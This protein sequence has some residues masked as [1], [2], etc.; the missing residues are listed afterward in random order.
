MAAEPEDMPEACKRERLCAQVDSEACE[1]DVDE[2]GEAIAGTLGHGDPVVG[3]D[4]THELHGRGVVDGQGMDDGA[5]C[6][7]R[8]HAARHLVGGEVYGAGVVHAHVCIRRAVGRIRL[9]KIGRRQDRVA[10]LLCP[11]AALPPLCPAPR[12]ALPRPHRARHQVRGKVDG[13]G[14][15]HA[16]VPVC[17]G[18]GGVLL[19]E[20]GRG[21]HRA[22]ARLA[23][24]CPDHPR[25]APAVEVRLDRRK[26]LWLDPPVLVQDGYDRTQAYDIEKKGIKM[27]R[28]DALD[29]LTLVLLGRRKVVRIQKT[30]YKFLCREHPSL[31]SADKR[32]CRSL[33]R[34]MCDLGQAYNG[35]T[36]KAANGR[37]DL[38]SPPPGLTLAPATQDQVKNNNYFAYD[39]LRG[40]LQRTPLSDLYFSD[41][42]IEALQNA[43]RYRVYNE[44][45]G[46]YVIGTQ[47]TIELQIIMRS[48]FLQYAQFRECDLVEQVRLLNQ[49]VLDY[50]VPNVVS[51]LKQYE[52]YRV[53]AS[54]LPMPISYGSYSGM[55]GSRQLEFNGWL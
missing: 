47:S 25:L 21:P 28:K 46:K 55:K 30:A 3:K 4:G 16:D 34:G 11:L 8:P 7:R 5:A 20:V 39:A 18:E 24:R 40:Q 23:G 49:Y 2:V 37:I 38:L 19:P 45:N 50:A 35:C 54:T 1:A 52:K 41:L 31:E 36:S 53:D 26:V 10:A 43:I 29:A 17:S 51:N 12:L 27:V 44:T 6:Q 32:K 14:V 15:V 13:P 22:P 42:N 48:I 33:C 9:A